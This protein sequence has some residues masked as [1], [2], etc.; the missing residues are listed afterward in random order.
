[1]LA[2]RF[3]SN[4]VLAAR[5]L[6]VNGRKR[7]SSARQAD[8]SARFDTGL[9]ENEIVWI[10]VYGL[11]KWRDRTAKDL[12]FMVSEESERMWT[13][14]TQMEHYQLDAS[15]RRLQR[16]ASGGFAKR[17]PPLGHLRF[18]RKS[19]RVFRFSERTIWLLLALED[20]TG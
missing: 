20:P 6:L 16:A 9:V 14:F 11:R 8:W 15:N 19:F 18:P 7:A 1:M 4:R 2:S 17:N 13:D 10:S 3:R 5:I 12:A